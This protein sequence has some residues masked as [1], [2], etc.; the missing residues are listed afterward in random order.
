MQ[1]R[2][3]DIPKIADKLAGLIKKLSLSPQKSNLAVV[4]ALVGD[5]GSGKTFFTRAFAEI[6]GIKEKVVSPT[7][8]MMKK[9]LILN[10]EFKKLG[11]KKLAHFDIYRL[12]KKEEMAVFGWEELIAD[13]SNIIFIEW[14]E[15]IAGLLTLSHFFIKF[16]HTDEKIRDID[17]ILVK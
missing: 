10:P 9:F 14:A 12:E 3:K 1:A 16:N 8:V 15:K 7:F 13:S 17:I 4:V 6:L 5:L 2:E 11:F